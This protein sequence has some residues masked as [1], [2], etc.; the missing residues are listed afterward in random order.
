M[1]MEIFRFN[2]SYAA[3]EFYR[4]FL[5]NLLL[6]GVLSAG[7]TVIMGLFLS[8]ED[9]Y[10]GDVLQWHKWSGVSLFYLSCLIYWSRNKDWYKATVAR[11]GA[12]LAVLFLIVAGHYGAVITHGDNF[13]TSP[14]NSPMKAEPVAIDQAL[15][16]DNVIQPIFQQKCVSCHNADKLKGELNLAD[17]NAI[18]KGGKS[19]KLF[20]AGNSGESLLFQR[21]HLPAEE[22]NTCRRRAKRS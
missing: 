10:T 21:I 6:V 20:K 8:K 3:N 13:I 2:T 22:K 16:F 1:A 18:L 17:V 4:V 9:G 19:G 15:V 11:S 14:F 12:I 5:S 7:I